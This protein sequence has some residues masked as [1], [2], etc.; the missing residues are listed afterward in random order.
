MNQ[1]VIE[2]AVFPQMEPHPVSK[3]VLGEKWA[4][5]WLVVWLWE[6]PSICCTERGLQRLARPSRGC[7]CICPHICADVLRSRPC[8]CVFYSPSEELRL[9]DL[10]RVWCIKEMIGGDFS[11]KN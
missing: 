3:M 1:L 10:N 4:G 9:E 11:L 7:P 5:W 8:V 6:D 2:G